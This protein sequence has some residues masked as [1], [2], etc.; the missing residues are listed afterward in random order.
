MTRSAHLAHFAGVALLASTAACS[1]APNRL[2][3]R[4]MASVAMSTQM[5]Y[6]VWTPK[7]FDAEAEQLPMMVFLHGGGDDENAFDEFSVGQHLD[8]ALAAGD[9]PRAVVVVPQGDMGF[10]ENWYDGSKHYRD[11]VVQEVI[12]DVQAR[13]HTQ[14]CPEGCHVA[15]VSMG[16]HGTMRMMWFHPELFASAASLSGPILSTEAILDFTDRL[17]VK[18]FIPVDD[19]WGPTDD[20]R[21]LEESDLFVQWNKQQDLKGVRL[22]LGVATDDREE[23]IDL[24]R[25]FHSH[26]S[27]SH[28][29]HEYIEFPGEHK[30]VSWTPVIDKVL[31]FAIWGTM[32]ATQ[33]ASE[34]AHA[35]ASPE[36]ALRSSGEAPA[37]RVSAAD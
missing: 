20:R 7:D 30:W 21:K 15:G 28:I 19:I 22:M 34:E 23:L 31:R 36:P 24:N 9:I 17:F 29:D 2:D 16:G 13:Y 18:L 35:D 33:P 37:D 5:A 12:P 26:L 32:D 11:W 27:R 25:K 10:W 3:H 8:A 6:E 14:K 4:E 1:S